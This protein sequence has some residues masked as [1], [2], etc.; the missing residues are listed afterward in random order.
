MNER[1]REEEKIMTLIVATM[2]A[3][4]PVYNNAW[5]AHALRSDQLNT[6]NIYT[7]VTGLEVTIQMQLRQIAAGR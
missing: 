5:A 1:E 6:S 4:Q 7:N 3:T 2:F